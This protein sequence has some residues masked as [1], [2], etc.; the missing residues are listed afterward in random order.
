MKKDNRP[1]IIWLLTGC[2][3]LFIMVMV[4]GITRLT[5]SELEVVSTYDF[6]DDGVEEN[7]VLKMSSN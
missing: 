3:L 6:N 7:V 2:V 4:G 1:V 5:N